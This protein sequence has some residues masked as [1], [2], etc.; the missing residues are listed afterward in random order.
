MKFLLSQPNLDHDEFKEIK[1]I[2]NRQWLINGPVVKKF[3]NNFKNKFNYKNA[4]TVSSCTAGL[5]LVLKSLD[6]KP[7][8]EIIISSFNFI[9]SGLVTLQQNLKP[10]FIDL[11]KNS[12]DIC[13]DSLKKKINKNTG[14]II[15]THFNGYL[16]PIN[17][18]KKILK[19]YPKIKLI[20]DAA[21]VLG[22]TDENKTYVGQKSYAAVFS[23]GPTKMI[24]S[25]GMGG[26]VVS[27]EKK[28][29][30]N[31]NELKSY[32]M[33]K[34][35]YDRKKN[36]KSWVYEIKKLG[37][38]YR[39][40]EIQAAVGITQLKKLNYFIN[41]RN[42]LIKEYEKFLKNIKKINFQ[43]S[44][45]TTNRSVIYFV[46][47]LKNQLVRDSLAEYLR[48]K[49]VGISVHWDPPLS[50]HYL[51]KKFSKKSDITNSILLAKKL[52]TLP[53][54]TKMTTKDVK[55]ICKFIKNFF[56]EQN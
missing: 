22:A 23:F 56:H 33:S 51:F 44:N 54:H 1:K 4:T 10:V 36:A 3:E 47:I 30:S 15:V 25:A 19:K 41:K 42:I 8:S 46:I 14:A 20:E 40:T 31:I 6:L 43:Y 5:E 13:L 55:Q 16:Q 29:I 53:L 17:P 28:L 45:F 39:M 26:M 12:F 37:N 27:R 2:Y 50:N 48:E 9:S 38:N 52:I 18:I 49:N 21:H 24:T 34:S 35:S 11:K 32:G 7:K